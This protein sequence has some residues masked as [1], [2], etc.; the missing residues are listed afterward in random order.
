[1]RSTHTHTERERERER[2]RGGRHAACGTAHALRAH[3]SK[4]V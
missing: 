2:G 3:A 1:L 4:G